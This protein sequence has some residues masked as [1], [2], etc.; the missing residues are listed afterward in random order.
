MG[1]LQLDLEVVSMV[2][3]SRRI[4]LCGGFLMFEL[5]FFPLFIARL[6]DI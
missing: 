5:C 3:A 2:V 1:C 4:E 6:Y